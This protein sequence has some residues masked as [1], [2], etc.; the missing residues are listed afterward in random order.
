MSMRVTSVGSWVL[1]GGGAGAGGDRDRLPS[2]DGLEDAAMAVHGIPLLSKKALSA[3][4]HHRVSVIPAVQPATKG[5]RAVR[6]V[7]PVT[8]GCAGL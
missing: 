8:P 3:S 2:C 6:G 4:R 7:S 1:H 5:K